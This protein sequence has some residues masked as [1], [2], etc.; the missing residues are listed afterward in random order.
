MKSLVRKWLMGNTV[1]SEYSKITN[2]D[3]PQQKVW[4][5]SNERITDVSSTHWLLCIEPLIF[6]V[7]LDKDPG[8]NHGRY[9]EECDMHFPLEPHNG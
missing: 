1:F 5:K 6:G 9:T 4:M 3:E 2:A 8:D 7:W